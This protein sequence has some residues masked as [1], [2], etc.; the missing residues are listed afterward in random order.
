MQISQLPGL[1]GTC[2]FKVL[3]I[4]IITKHFIL[5]PNYFKITIFETAILWTITILL[6]GWKLQA[7]WLP[8]R[9]E[10]GHIAWS[11]TFTGQ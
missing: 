1:I 9:W 6:S 2:K 3:L 4:I 7:S 10:H 11:A 5:S 8:D